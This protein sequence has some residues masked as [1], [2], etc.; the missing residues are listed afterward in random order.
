MGAVCFIIALVLFVVAA[1]DGHIGSLNLVPL[2]LAFLAG[3]HI[4]GGGWPFDRGRR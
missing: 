2:G 4:L 1:F 3:G